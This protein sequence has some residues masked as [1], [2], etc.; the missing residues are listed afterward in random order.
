MGSKI[1][2]RFY[3]KA[4][5]AELLI[6]NGNLPRLLIY[7]QVGSHPARIISPGV[8]LRA[9]LKKAAAGNPWQWIHGMLFMPAAGSSIG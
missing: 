8:H 1:P 3:R 9:D 7:H 5:L 6:G 4:R 2:C